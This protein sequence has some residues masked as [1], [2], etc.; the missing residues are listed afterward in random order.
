MYRDF[1]DNEFWFSIFCMLGAI[2]VGLI[3]AAYSIYIITLFAVLVMMPM[4]LWITI[5]V[6][7]K[8]HFN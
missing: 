7:I 5:I 2:F 4:G 3:G 8:E 6:T 1:T